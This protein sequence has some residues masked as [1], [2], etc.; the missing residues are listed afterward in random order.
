[1]KICLFVFLLTTFCVSAQNDSI[2]TINLPFSIQRIKITDLNND[3]N[4][5][6]FIMSNAL[7]TS[8]AICSGNGTLTFNA[9]VTYPKE[10]NFVN[11]DTGDLNMDGYVDFVISSYW[12]NGFKIFYGDQNGHYTFASAHDMESHA[13]DVLITDVNK[14]EY[15]DIVGITSGSG[16][17]VTLHIYQ[18]NAGNNF[19]KSGKYPTLLSGN[20]NTYAIDKNKDNL[21]D[22]AV[23]TRNWIALF[24][25]QTNGE[26]Q[27]KYWPTAQAD[28][29]IAD[30]NNDHN[31]DIISAYTSYDSENNIDS[32]FIRFGEQDTLFSSPKATFRS[33][34]MGLGNLCVA[35]IDFDNV[36]D[37][38]GIHKNIFGENTDSIYIFKGYG[39][40]GFEL[41][42]ILKLQQPIKRIVIADLKKDLFPEIIVV[43]ENQLKIINNSGEIMKPPSK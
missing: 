23:S 32:V 33:I 41:S 35:N 12:F 40:N 22:I 15:P 30:V 34:N 11:F 2:S 17:P 25:Q 26:F 6:I 28:V 31:P 8:F 36:P 43:C 3:N 5:D 21:I 9:P 7:E 13:T 10:Q 42:R 27:L 19:I 29:T 38:I 18:N 4:D 37:L 14:D 16:K 24:Y 39:N 20:L 1:M